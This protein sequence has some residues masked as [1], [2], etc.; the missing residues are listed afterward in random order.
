MPVDN[1]EPEFYDQVFNVYNVSHDIFVGLDLG[2]VYDLLINFTD[3][4]AGM[5]PV[6]TA[7]GEYTTLG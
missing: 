1:H 2:S 6:V 7:P 5:E 3:L 4:D